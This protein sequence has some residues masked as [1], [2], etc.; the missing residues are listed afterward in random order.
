MPRSQ[1]GRNVFTNALLLCNDCHKE[2]HADNDLL[3]HWKEVF[4]K[5]YGPLYFMDQDDLKMKYLTQELQ[6]EDKAVKEWERYNETDYRTQE[7]EL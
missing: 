1:S 6:Q 7:T 2:V 3:R 5:K 4:R